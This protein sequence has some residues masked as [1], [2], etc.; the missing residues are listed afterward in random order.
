[1]EGANDTPGAPA[2]TTSRGETDDSLP[3]IKRGSGKKKVSQACVYCQRSHMTCDRD[4]PCQRCVKRRIG[5]LCHD[6]PTSFPSDTSSM[7]SHLATHAARKDGPLGKVPR[8]RG[9]DE[10]DQEETP[11]AP[12]L[13]V[14]EAARI[15]FSLHDQVDSIIRRYNPDP[16]LSGNRP[17]DEE[18]SG[19]SLMQFL[20]D[21]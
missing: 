6:S 14:K 1:M 16:D 13:R 11:P 3:L 4:R 15:L 20:N 5:H 18:Q 2:K 21:Q 9:G 8:D 10:V 17:F 19:Q 7:V 12:S